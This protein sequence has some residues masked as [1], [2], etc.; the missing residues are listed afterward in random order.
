MTVNVQSLCPDAIPSSQSDMPDNF[1]GKAGLL[2][3]Q[4][5]AW[6]MSV[7]ALQETRAPKN[8]TIQ[9]KTHIRFCSARDAQ[10][11]YGTELWFSKS[12]PFIRHDRTPIYFGADDFLAV[13]W[14]PRIIA[15]R[16]RRGSLR[17]LFVSLHAPTSASPNRRQWWA[18]FRRLIDRLR[19]GSQVALLGDFN[20]H[21]HRAFGDRVGDLHWSTP[22]PPQNHSG[23][24]LMPTTS[25]YP[26]PSAAATLARPRHGSPR[27]AT[28]L[29]G[30]TMLPYQLVGR[31][32]PGAVKSY[33]N[34]TGARA[35]QTITRY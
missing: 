32:Q 10:G 12:I 15:V 7:T 21:L 19:Q 16:F 13:H 6:N 8:E 18:D 11:S 17:I 9:S 29:P 20:L 28:V 4:L 14:D 26:V 25:G 33:L 31:S 30:W 3:E 24:S 34:L 35:T 22:T 5:T 1:P 2:R 27:T 23:N